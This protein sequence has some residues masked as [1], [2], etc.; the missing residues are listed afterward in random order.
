[1]FS[2]RL[3][4]AI[5]FIA[6]SVATGRKPPNPSRRNPQVHDAILD[7]AAALLAEKGYA[8]VTIDAIASRAGAG[9]QTI[10][11]WW[12]SKAAIFMEVYNRS[13]QATI[14]EAGEI[15]TGSLAGDVQALILGLRSLF[16]QTIAGKALQGM[17][18]EVQCN[19][20]AAQP[21]LQFM[22]ERFQ[23]AHRIYERALARNEIDPG[24]DRDTFVDLI[25]GP[26][27]YRLLIEH[28]PLDE[29]FAMQMARVVISG[30]GS[31][32]S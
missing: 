28:A 21:F 6:M 8:G 2:V 4:A 29:A 22:E 26:I 32:E 11:R 17:V 3:N 31:R 16:S 25:G 15:D 7:A 10:Y 18:A 27:M 30:V 24:I 12:S 5:Q 20:S 1:L 9:R 19:P 13:A 23:I 14:G